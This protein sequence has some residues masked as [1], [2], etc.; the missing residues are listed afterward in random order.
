MKRFLVLLL[1]FVQLCF[2]QAQNKLTF[3]LVPNK[4][5]VA[6]G[7]TF[8]VNVNAK[9]FI[10]LV[11]LQFSVKW[12]KADYSFISDNPQALPVASGS[13]N[14]GTNYYAGIS[15]W[16]VSWNALNNGT[17][18]TDTTIIQIKL[19]ALK[20]GTV[21]NICFE[22][23]DVDTDLTQYNSSGQ[24]VALL[25]SDFI[26]LNC[27]FRFTQSS[28]GVKTFTPIISALSYLATV[29]TNIYPNPFQST[30]NIAFTASMT[31]DVSVALYNALG[32]MVLFQKEQARQV[33]P[34][35]V[36]HL[37]TGVYYYV[38]KT[39]QGRSIGKVLKQ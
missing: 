39:N 29:E 25:E 28:L 3:S 6:V 37:P 35:N 11:S 22:P 36:E 38:I 14:Y 12:N 8:I 7:D 1:F 17:T 23:K 34:L 19:K 27:G 30:L 16:F 15:T 32:R 5:T 26:G 9:N 2:V 10:R 24:I 31:S 20:S 13:S 18:L 21:T 33:I 4:T